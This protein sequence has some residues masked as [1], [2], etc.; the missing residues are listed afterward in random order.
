MSASS[1]GSPALGAP[2]DHIRL[3]LVL[4]LTAPGVSQTQP[5]WL[6]YGCHRALVCSWACHAPSPGPW[7][8]R[9]GRPACASRCGP[10]ATSPGRGRVLHGTR[11]HEA[12]AMTMLAAPSCVPVSAPQQASACA[13]AWSTVTLCQPHCT[14]SKPFAPV[15]AA[16]GLRLLPAW[17]AARLAGG[18]P[19]GLPSSQPW[20]AGAAER[21]AP[22][23][24]GRGARRCWRVG[25]VKSGLFSLYSFLAQRHQLGVFRF[26]LRQRKE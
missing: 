24:Q 7:V 4:R 14:S 17:G 2:P 8:G 26:E 6:A 16:A 10:C 11:L 25:H 13:R 23:G 20:H 19:G 15:F 5:C 12:L 3:R 22:W 18:Q 21:H 1:Q 9:H